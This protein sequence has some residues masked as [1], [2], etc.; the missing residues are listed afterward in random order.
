MYDDIKRTTIDNVYDPSPEEDDEE[1]LHFGVK[2]M[3]WG[4]RKKQETTGRKPGSTKSKTQQNKAKATNRGAKKAAIALGVIGGTALASYGVYKAV[5]GKKDKAAAQRAKEQAAA[6]AEAAKRVAAARSS[7]TRTIN[8]TRS[9][10][11]STSSGAKRSTASSAADTARRYAEAQARLQESMRR[12]QAAYDE[13]D[14]VQR[15]YQR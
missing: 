3:K 4:V 8:T 6:M 13:L 11:S 15:K 5:K 12:A 14:R 9:S 1:L 10:S 2:G 7:G